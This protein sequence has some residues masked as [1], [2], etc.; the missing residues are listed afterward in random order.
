MKILLTFD[1]ELFFGQNSGSLDNCLINPT[2]YLI[3][4][5]NQYDVK[6]T[7]FVDVGYIDCL[8]RNRKDYLELDIEYNKITSHISSL[9]NSGHDIQLHIHPH[10]KDCNF[11][12]KIWDID[13]RRYRLHDFPEEEVD[14]IVKDYKNKL[15]EITGKRIIAYRGGGWCIQPFEHIKKALLSNG[16]IIDSTVF[17]GGYYQSDTHYFDFHEAEEKTIWRFEDDPNNEEKSGSFVEIPI[18]SIRTS[19]LFF[20]KLAMAKK[21][22]GDIHKSFGDGTA[23]KA[24]QANLIRMLTTYTSTVVSMDGYK[25]SLLKKAFEIYNK[26]YKEKDYFVAIGHPKSLSPYALKKI[27][28][29]IKHTIDQNIYTTYQREVENGLLE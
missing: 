2:N 13:T 25:S 16:V 1:Y 24:D 28:E 23:V 9:S 18:S 17:K 20:W 5:L 22:G 15:E 29:F 19:P 27:D 12:G 6:A 11:N 3:K 10:W 21:M 7:F 8:N 26:K 14:Q 4:I